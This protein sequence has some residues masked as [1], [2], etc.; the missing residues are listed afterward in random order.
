MAIVQPIGHDSQMPIVPN[1]TDSRNASIT[2]RNRSVN[3]A[4]I[5]D[6]MAP[7]RAG[8]R[9]PSASGKSQNRRATQSAKLCSRFHGYGASLIHK[10]RQHGMASEK[11]A[12]KKGTVIIKASFT[13]ALNPCSTLSCFPAPG[14]VRQ[15][16]WYRCPE[17]SD[18]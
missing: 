10:Q 14:S 2:R 16:C 1:L 6:F 15:S 17:S 5:K 7:A 9:P 13:E 18:W 4:I 11:N 8:P 12:A 3:V